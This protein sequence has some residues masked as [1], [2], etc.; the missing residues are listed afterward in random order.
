[1]R[2]YRSELFIYVSKSLENSLP[3]LLIIYLNGS[4]VHTLPSLRFFHS[5]CQEFLFQLAREEKSEVP[6]THQQFAKI[7]VDKKNFES[8]SATQAFH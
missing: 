6:P 3:P 1:M 8:R 7:R 4:N 2:S 5:V